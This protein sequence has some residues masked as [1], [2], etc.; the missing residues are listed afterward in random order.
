M[1]VGKLSLFIDYMLVFIG[2]GKNLEIIGISLH[3]TQV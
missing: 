2:K 3:Q 1:K